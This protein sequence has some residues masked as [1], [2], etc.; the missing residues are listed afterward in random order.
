MEFIY[1]VIQENPDYFAWAFGLVNILWGAFV[2]F[3]KQRHDKDLVELTNSLKFESDR[4]L[5]VFELK[6]RK[7][8]E[9]VTTLDSFGKKHQV[10]LPKKMKPI[11]DKYLAD[12]LNATATENKEEEAKVIAW[13]SSQISELM[14]LASEDY[15]KIQAESSKLKLTATDEMVEAFDNLELLIKNG[16]DESTN[17]MSGFVE[18]VLSQNFEVGEKFQESAKISGEQIKRSSKELLN[19]MR[20]ELNQSTA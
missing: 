3:N 16:L 17:F 18:M 9:Y 14:H 4:K 20:A 8:E 12:Y 2:Y 11:I 13:F 15:I 10:D 1:K 19:L 7:F 5:K 6:V